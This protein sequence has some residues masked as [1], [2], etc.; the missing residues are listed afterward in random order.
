VTAA[1]AVTPRGFASMPGV[2]G[3][4]PL[5]EIPAHAFDRSTD[6]HSEELSLR[7]IFSVSLELLTLQSLNTAISRT[8][9][10]GA[11]A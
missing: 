8:Q 2:L 7:L 5:R 4:T 11:V 9:S 3:E 10:L 1:M 6:V